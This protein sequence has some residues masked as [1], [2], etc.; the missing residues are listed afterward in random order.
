VYKNEK[1]Y[2]TD[3]TREKK[4]RI[5]KLGDCPT[6]QTPQAGGLANNVGRKP[7]KGKGNARIGPRKKK[8]KDNFKKDTSHYAIPC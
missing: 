1:R 3:G 6:M 5:K 7:T 4:T 8:R 2:K